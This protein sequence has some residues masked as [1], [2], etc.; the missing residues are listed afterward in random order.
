MNTLRLGKKIPIN[1]KWLCFSIIALGLFVYPNKT[2]TVKTKTVHKKLSIQASNSE[3]PRIAFDEVFNKKT[4]QDWVPQKPA[5]NLNKSVDEKFA[6]STIQQIKNRKVTLKRMLVS[7]DDAVLEL[8]N[9]NWIQDLPSSQKQRVI[10][11]KVLESPDYNE[12][13]PEKTEDF[14]K[15]L[16]GRVKLVEGAALTDGHIEILVKKNGGQYSLGSVHPQT[17]EFTIPVEQIKEDSKVIAKVYDKQGN[18]TGQGSV[19]F[20]KL[21]NHEALEKSNRQPQIEVPVKPKQ[22]TI[23]SNFFLF[24]EY[25]SRLESNN[26]SKGYRPYGLKSETYVAS[27]DQNFE[28]DQTGETKINDIYPTSWVLARTQA[29]G[30]YPTLNLINDQHSIPLFRVKFIKAL[31]DISKNLQN[32]SLFEEN[33]S[34]IWGQAT[35]QNKPIAGIKI[36]TE[37]S[38]THKTIY[39]NELLIPDPSLKSTSSNG[40]FAVLHLKEGLHTLMAFRSDEYFGH[41]NVQTEPETLSYAKVES[42]ID[43]KN[44]KIKTF[45]A[46][47][48]EPL[49]TKIKI[50]SSQQLLEVEGSLDIKLQNL[51]RYSLMHIQSEDG[52]YFSSMQSYND[53]DEE[54]WAPVIP[55]NWI[56]QIKQIRKINQNPILGM[57][58]GFFTE[59]VIGDVYLSHDSEYL[60]SNIVY[61]NSAGETLDTPTFGGGYVLFN[62]LQG[63]HSVVVI[64][65][66]DNLVSSD[67]IFV[68]T[69]NI[70]VIKKSN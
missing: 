50:Q 44:T 28:S 43:F 17:G 14:T 53:K 11:S 52:Q 51:N 5:I 31:L 69:E 19:P 29:E 25:Y 18:V 36:E 40:F 34:V 42:N 62:V 58:V 41:I 63:T 30:Y 12:S 47:T 48:G 37:F 56:D 9:K 49:N 32:S 4:R 23:A 24:D 35:F 61:F 21:A 64:D 45:D 59:D 10:A 8:K 15:H 7:Y 46:L 33:N 67:V 65:N 2:K 26:R 16:K 1:Y 54:I 22:H 38:D 6:F 55:K 13:F 20:N 27:L 57:V 66:R 68:E 60:R 70:N 3:P 39:F